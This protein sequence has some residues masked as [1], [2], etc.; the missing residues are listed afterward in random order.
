M[1]SIKITW[2]FHKAS[3]QLFGRYWIRNMH[4]HDKDWIKV[5][6]FIQQIDQLISFNGDDLN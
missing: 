6:V 1:I 5:F 3:M 4:E 2:K